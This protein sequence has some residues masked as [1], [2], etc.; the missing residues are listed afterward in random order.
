MSDPVDLPPASPPLPRPVVVRTRRARFSLVWLVPI[1]ALIVGAAMLARSIQQ[2]G[3][4]ITI[5]F[6]HAEGLEANHTEVRFKE[7][8][9]G[10]VTKVALSPDRER[11]IASVSLDKSVQSLAVADTRFWVV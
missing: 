1:V 8:V 10:R 3:P 4:E 6:R 11:V 9:V 7:V 5:S 2:R